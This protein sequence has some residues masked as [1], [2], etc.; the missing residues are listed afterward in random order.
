MKNK[1]SKELNIKS[2]KNIHLVTEEND[3]KF[4]QP[5][6]YRHLRIFA[7]FF[8]AIAQV[9]IILGMANNGG[10]ISANETFLTILA[11]ANSMMTPLFIFAAFAQVLT[12]KD[13]YKR[14]L[15]VYGLGALGIFV[16]FAFVFF[17]YGVGLI[18]SVSDTWNNAYDTAT[19]FMKLLNTN[20]VVSFNVFIDL[21]LCTLVM[22]FVNH[23]PTRHFQDK[24]I[25]IFRSL[26]AIPILLELVS[27]VIKILATNGTITIAPILIPL[28]TTKPPVAFLIFIALA[29]FIKFRERYY[30][31]KG[32]SVEDY[33]K[34]LNTNV[35][36]IQFSRFLC[37]SILGA[38]VLD[39]ILFILISVIQIASTGGMEVSE[40]IMEK[41]ISSVYFA[42]FGNCL[43]MLFIIP[44]LAFFDYTKTYKNAWVDML[45]PLVGVA[46]LVLVYFEGLF[47]IL[48]GY[49]SKFVNSL[50]EDDPSTQALKEIKKL[51]GK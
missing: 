16:G 10:L 37:F 24:K 40:E 49:L 38:V 26:V 39:L 29:L 51:I 21:I 47:E 50:S 5:F 34:F 12:V 48:K 35:N 3:V 8:L 43:P 36:R 13:G 18:N 27:I 28:L 32:K 31:K 4:R 15:I 2:R 19:A 17:H 6:S 42:G 1:E 14:L 7:W 30:L 20:G 9:G 11:S 33:K 45:I 46:L 22:F 23:R 25:Y 44:I 41:T